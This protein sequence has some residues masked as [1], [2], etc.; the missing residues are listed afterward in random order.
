MGVVLS[1]DLDQFLDER[2]Y[3]IEQVEAIPSKKPTQQPL[4]AT[5]AGD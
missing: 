5:A 1:L 4:T 2:K 3:L